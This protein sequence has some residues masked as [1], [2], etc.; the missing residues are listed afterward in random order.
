MENQLKAMDINTLIEELSCFKDVDTCNNC[1]HDNFCRANSMIYCHKL[2]EIAVKYLDASEVKDIITNCIS[3]RGSCL[4][5][6][7]RDKETSCTRRM[8]REAYESLTLCTIN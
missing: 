5:C 8:M 6:T 3:G 4:S 2:L 7:Y 1:K